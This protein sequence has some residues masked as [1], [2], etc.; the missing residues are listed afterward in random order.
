MQWNAEKNGGFSSADDLI[1]PVI[2]EGPFRFSEINAASQL[3]QDGS[4]LQWMKRL[5]AARKCFP[6]VGLCPAQ[7]LNTEEQDDRAIAHYFGAP[8]NHPESTPLA[9]FHNLSDQPVTA[10]VHLPAL[11]NR[12]LNPQVKIGCGQ[13]TSFEGQKLSVELPA[14]GYLWIKA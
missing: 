1:A 13:I 11:E 7:L 8:K 2:D 5:I 4:L 14:F 9:L 10:T 6:G 3:E 12:P